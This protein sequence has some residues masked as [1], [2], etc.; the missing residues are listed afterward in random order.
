MRSLNRY[1]VETVFLNV[2]APDARANARRNFPGNRAGLLGQ[3]RAT[4][5]LVSIASH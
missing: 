1:I 5:F 4:N 2:N 3:F